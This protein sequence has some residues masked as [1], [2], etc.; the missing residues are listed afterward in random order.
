MAK[1]GW[2]VTQQYTTSDSSNTPTVDYY[3]W[4]LKPYVQA[5]GN[6]VSTLF[7]QNLW[8]NV[9][10]FDIEQFKLNVFVSWILTDDFAICPGLGWE[11][12]EILMKLEWTMKF[13]NCNKTLLNNLADLSSTWTGYNAKYFEDC[14]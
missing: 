5:Q 1:A 3:E 6:F 9:I 2:E 8:V 12:E 7:I 4:Q 14:N 13:W 11:T 10:T